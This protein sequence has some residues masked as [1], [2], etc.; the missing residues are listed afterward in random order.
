MHFPRQ[1]VS[2]QVVP[3]RQ[4]V[5]RL[6]WKIAFFQRVC[7]PRQAIL[8]LPWKKTLSPAESEL[9]QGSFPSSPE[10]STLQ[11]ERPIPPQ[12]VRRSARLRARQA[13]NSSRE[14]SNVSQQDNALPQGVSPRTMLPKKQGPSPVGTTPCRVLPL[15]RNLTQSG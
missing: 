7:S 14:V 4:A 6:P 11:A 8:R 5:P 1:A 3:S 13:G 12:A 2:R 15:W 9:S 10:D